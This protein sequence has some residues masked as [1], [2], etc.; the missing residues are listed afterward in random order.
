MF[1]HLLF[2]IGEIYSFNK[3]SWWESQNQIYAT[4]Y[5]ASFDNEIIDATPKNGMRYYA[6][7]NNTFFL[8]STTRLQLNFFYSSKQNRGLSSQGARHGLDIGL[9][10]SFMDKKLQVA[11]FA[12]DIFDKGSLNN[13][14]SEVNGVEVNFGMNYSRRYVRLSM[15]YN[16]GNNK[17]NV[18]ERKF[19][20]ADETSRSN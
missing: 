3:F 5:K 14:L 12:K 15:T 16:F 13:S 2:G 17:I 1:E 7:T 8:N 4:Y 19:G 20:N 10:K 6:S 11:L 9:R 18:R